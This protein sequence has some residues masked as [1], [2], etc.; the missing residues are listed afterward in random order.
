MKRFVAVIGVMLLGLACAVAPFS[1]SAAL[2]QGKKDFVKLTTTKGDIVLE[3]DAAKAP[4]T[5]ENFLKYVKDGYY[6]G[7]I[8]HRVISGFMIQG[9]GMDKGMNPKA[10]R[11]P[12]QNEADNG[13]KNEAY[14]VAM[15]RTNDPHSATGQFFINVVNNTMLNHTAK[16]P[17]GWGYAVFGNVVEGKEVVDAIKAVPTGTKGNY[18]NVPREPVEIIKAEVVQR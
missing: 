10:G 4:A 3:L 16:T 12:I 14:T 5:V 1:A 7:L 18:E 6:N 15:A 17:A 8:F 2:A 11:A 9:G 13:L